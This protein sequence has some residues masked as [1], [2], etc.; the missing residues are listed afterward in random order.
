MAGF[1]LYTEKV[2]RASRWAFVDTFKF[3][4]PPPF[5]LTEFISLHFYKVLVQVLKDA[6]FYKIQYGGFYYE[7][8]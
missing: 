8:L 1:P 7:L 4:I 5:T 2:E 3:N 6:L